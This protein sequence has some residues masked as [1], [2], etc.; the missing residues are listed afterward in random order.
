MFDDHCQSPFSSTGSDLVWGTIL[1]PRTAKQTL[2]V[3]QGTPL[4][5]I[6]WPLCSKPRHPVDDLKGAARDPGVSDF[7][8]SPDPAKLGPFP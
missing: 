7:H 8:G 2:H 5:P 6:F 3:R 4:R 1:V